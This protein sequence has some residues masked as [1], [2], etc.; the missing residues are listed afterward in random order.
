MIGKLSRGYRQRVGLADALLGHPRILLL[1]E[2]TT[3][4]DP[5]QV[6]DLRR[7]LT[8]LPHSP[9]ILFSSHTL[10][11]V[12]MFCSRLLILSGGKL[13]ANGTRQGLRRSLLAGSWQRWQAHT[14]LRLIGDATSAREL[15]NLDGARVESCIRHRGEVHYTLSLREDESVHGRVLALLTRPDGEE[16][17]HWEREMPVIE[18]IFLAATQQNQEYQP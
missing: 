15:E 14:T 4:L 16:L 9:T 8:N 12:D 10:G 5:N 18:S 7:I 17:V 2:P 1:D 3:G 13:I 6:R 11:E